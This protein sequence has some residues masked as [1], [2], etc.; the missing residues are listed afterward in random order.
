MRHLT[1]WAG[2]LVLLPLLIVILASDSGPEA[3]P[4]SR[5]DGTSAPPLSDEEP[6]P[7][8]PEVAGPAPET[9][10]A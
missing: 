8:S 10:E 6:A 3:A 2:P 9:V 4:P 1:R 5:P 7:P